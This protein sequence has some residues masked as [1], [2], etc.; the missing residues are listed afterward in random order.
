[1]RLGR[2][3]RVVSKNMYIKKAGLIA[4]FFDKEKVTGL[5]AQSLLNAIKH[6]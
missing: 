6:F 5:K 4:G 1:M 3:A 2:L